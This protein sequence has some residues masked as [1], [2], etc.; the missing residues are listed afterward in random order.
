MN[1]LNTSRHSLKFTTLRV[2][3]VSPLNR[4]GI[5]SRCPIVR[6]VEAVVGFISTDQTKGSQQ[7]LAMNAGQVKTFK[8]LQRESFQIATFQMDGL[9]QGQG[10]SHGRT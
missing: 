4:V 10:D 7:E 5:S 1:R 8:L 9:T 3:L 2:N 6:A